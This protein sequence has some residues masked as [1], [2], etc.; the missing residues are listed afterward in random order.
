V[1]FECARAIQI[2]YHGNR[3]STVVPLAIGWIS[4]VDVAG[5][6]NLAPFSHS[7]IYLDAAGKRN[8]L[9]EAE[10]IR[11]DGAAR[12]TVTSSCGGTARSGPLRVMV[13]QS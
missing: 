7:T 11:F 12:L 8:P 4:T 1:S 2:S 5:A 6:I 9:C 13:A 10:Q 3:L